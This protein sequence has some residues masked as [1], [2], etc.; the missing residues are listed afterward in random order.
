MGYYKQKAIEE[1][2]E[3]MLGVPEE[4][5]VV[6]QEDFLAALSDWLL[7]NREAIVRMVNEQ[8]PLIDFK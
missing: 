5:E 7:S 3:M 4:P 8:S 2:E 6:V 1:Y